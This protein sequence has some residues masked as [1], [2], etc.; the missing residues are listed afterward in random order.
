MSLTTGVVIP[1]YNAERFIRDALEGVARQSHPPDWAVVVDDG[2]EDRTADTVMEWAASSKLRFVLH[3][4]ENRGLPAARNAGI[5]RLPEADLIALLDADDIWE[6]WHLERCVRALE[7]HEDLVLC[8]ADHQPFDCH[9]PAGGT[10][11]E[12]KVIHGLPSELRDDGVTA[13]SGPVFESLLLGNYIPPSTSVFRRKVA[14]GIQ[15][16]DPEMRSCED[17]DFFLRLSRVGRFAFFDQVHAHYRLHDQNMSHPRNRLHMQT[18]GHRALRK[19]RRLEQELQLEREEAVAV[20]D[21]ERRQARSLLSTAS[22]TGLGEY[23]SASAEVASSGRLKPILNPK[24]LARAIRS[25]TPWYRPGPQDRTRL[26]P[27]QDG[28]GRRA[29]IRR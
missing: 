19:I 17:R 16:F 9:G 5:V 4:Q 2:S 29:S 21:A 22:R 12:D 13:L 27:E 14:A 1:A 26:H 7:R 25:S 3:R 11:L 28:A 24:N 15:F 6:P 18:W 23:L 20:S 8:F 10:F